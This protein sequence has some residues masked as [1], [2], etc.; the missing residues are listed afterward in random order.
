M[1][2]KQEEIAKNSCQL[3]QLWSLRWN[4]A[5]RTS[6][7]RSPLQKARP[8]PPPSLL[9]LFSCSCLQALATKEKA[10][11]LWPKEASGKGFPGSKKVENCR[12]CP[13]PSPGVVG[14]NLG[15][16]VCVLEGCG[17]AGHSWVGTQSGT[18]AGW[19]STFYSPPLADQTVTHRWFSSPSRFDT[20]LTGFS[21]GRQHLVFCS[22]DGNSCG[23]RIII[24]PRG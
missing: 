1:N 12:R 16:R 8:L 19:R 15:G 2:I 20:M 17:P 18:A 3:F 21:G 9:S 6:C 14:G 11:T 23:R 10:G 7:T 22:D 24:G 4:D 13:P 5:W